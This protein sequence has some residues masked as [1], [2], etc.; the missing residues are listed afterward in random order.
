MEVI[1]EDGSGKPRTALSRLVIPDDS[2]P[3]LMKRI[4]VGKE[5]LTRFFSF[6]EFTVIQIL[7]PTSL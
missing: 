3:R 1:L 5:T 4:L 2:Y 7:V 6:L